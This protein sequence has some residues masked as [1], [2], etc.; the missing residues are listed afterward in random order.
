MNDQYIIVNIGSN[1][2]S[3]TYQRRNI[4]F[5]ERDGVDELVYSP[6]NFSI[7][8]SGSS[9]NFTYRLDGGTDGADDYVEKV[10]VSLAMFYDVSS[11]LT[12]SCLC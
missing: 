4:A 6:G 11:S 12:E 10:A 7:S 3:S 8:N 1:S 5:T 9:F 2:S